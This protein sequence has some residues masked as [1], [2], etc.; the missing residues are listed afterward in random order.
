MADSVRQLVPEELSIEREGAA[1]P[2][3]GRLRDRPAIVLVGLTGAG[4]TTTV[5]RLQA[6][7]PLAAV[8]PDRR[9]MTDRLIL[10]MMTGSS[11]PVTDRVERFRLTAAFKER[12]PGGMG[13]L[14]GRLVLPADLPPGPVLFDGLRG[15]A[16][17]SAAAT[18]ETARFLVLECS[19]EGRLRRLCGRDDPFDRTRAGGTPPAPPGAASPDAVAA[20]RQAI[21]GAGFDALVPASVADRLAAE[22][23]VGGTEAAAVAGMA[24][25]IVEESRHYDPAAAR[26][27]LQRLAPG[28]TLVIDTDRLASDQVAET[29][30][31]WS[32]AA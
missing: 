22:L 18:L 9:A 2:A 15:E 19:P 16:E 20:I 4:K 5:G 28:R 21:A 17:V 31:A 25:I 24:A 11:M 12:H 3:G 8:L 30:V 10:P 7:L 27:A 1:P 13:D 14:L 29:A 6:F 23:A 26:A 32:A